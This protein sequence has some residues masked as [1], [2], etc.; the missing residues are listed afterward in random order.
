MDTAHP[1]NIHSSVPH[2][3]ARFIDNSSRSLF[4]AVSTKA[5]Y[6]SRDGYLDCRSY[7]S[8]PMCRWSLCVVSR[9]KRGRNNRPL[10]PLLLSSPERRVEGTSPVRPVSTSS[11]PVN[12]GPGSSPRHLGRARDPVKVVVGREQTVKD[13]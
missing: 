6:G 4:S 12:R 9:T 13:T 2:P 1:W 5:H 11:G 8:F 10:P 7:L 3:S